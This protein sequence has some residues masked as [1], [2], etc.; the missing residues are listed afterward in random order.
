MVRR[1]L[2]SQECDGPFY[3]QG[4]V[5]ESWSPEHTQLP[6]TFFWTDFLMALGGQASQEGLPERKLESVLPTVSNEEPAHCGSI[7]GGKESSSWPLGGAATPHP[8]R[9]AAVRSPQSF[10]RPWK[11]Q[12]VKILVQKN[13][14]S[15]ELTQCLAH[16]GFI[17]H[18]WE[19]T[20]MERV[21][22]T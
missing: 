17:T 6:L 19:T 16:R 21:E 14:T 2:R 18:S 8:R 7:A 9:C 20:E 22:E 4:K 15:A 5:K 13:K 3:R 11:T 10:R 1:Y 12:Y